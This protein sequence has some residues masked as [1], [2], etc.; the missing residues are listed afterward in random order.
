VLAARRRRVELL[1]A[2]NIARVTLL[3]DVGGDFRPNSENL[4]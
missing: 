3:I 2:R 4:R 1:S